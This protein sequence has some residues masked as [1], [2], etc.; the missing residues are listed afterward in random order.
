M[1]E[2]M[3]TQMAIDYLAGMTDRSFN[4]LA[5]ETGFLRRNVEKKGVR[6]S[7]AS[8]SVQAVL[9]E[10]ERAEKLYEAKKQAGE[11]R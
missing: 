9:K 11:G 1:E 3:A 4:D 5:I 8:E 2:R 6:G 10:H 7:K